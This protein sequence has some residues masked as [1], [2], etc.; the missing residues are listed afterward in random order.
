MPAVMTRTS[1][2]KWD[3]FCYDSDDAL[4]D[5]LREFYEGSQHCDM[6]IKCGKRKW[7]VHKLVLALHSKVFK[8]ICYG[9]SKEA[10]EGLIDLSGNDVDVVDAMITF[11]YRLGTFD[12]EPDE[13]NDDAIEPMML[14]VRLYALADHFNIS[15]LKETAK[16]ELKELVER[17]PAWGTEEF[18]AAVRDMYKENY[19]SDCSIRGIALAVVRKQKEYLTLPW[20]SYNRLPVATGLTLGMRKWFI[21]EDVSKDSR[22]RLRRSMVLAHPVGVPKRMSESAVKVLRQ[23]REGPD[24]KI[25][26]NAP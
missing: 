15:E 20:I 6:V 16:D 3:G 9:S 2:K 8:E 12:H 17:E 24:Q 18:A 10:K 11:L 4:T 23:R 5:S 13:I 1:G 19:A 22:S 14:C 26:G 21:A 7:K 25:D